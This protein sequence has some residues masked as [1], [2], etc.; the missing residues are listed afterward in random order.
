MSCLFCQIADKKIPA[1]VVYEDD[2]VLAFRD[3]HPQAPLHILI[4]PKRHVSSLNGFVEG[5]ELLLGR[6]LLAAKTIAREQGV[7]EDGYRV[8]IN[9]NGLGG[10]TVYHLHVHLL[11]GRQFHWPPG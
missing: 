6:L 9:T 3:I 4:I 7:A 2:D 5:D 8:N 11:A 1:D 10:Q